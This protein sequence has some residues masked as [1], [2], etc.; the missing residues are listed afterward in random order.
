MMTSLPNIVTLIQ[1]EI[2]KIEGVKNENEV[3]EIEVL[4]TENEAMDP[5][6]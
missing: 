5:E 6:N 1:N 2:L 3:R 4:D